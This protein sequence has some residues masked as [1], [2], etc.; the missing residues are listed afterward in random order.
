MRKTLLLFMAA[1]LLSACKQEVPDNTYTFSVER[2]WDQNYSAFPSIEQ[3]NGHYFISFREGEDHIF[4]RNGIAAGK[5]RILRSKDGKEWESVALLSKEG[6]DLRDPKLSITPDG[7]L[8]IIMG[9]S[10]YVNKQ[11]EACIPQVSFSDDGKTFSDP[12]PVNYPDGT[13]FEW[14][15]RMTWH[16]GVGYTVTYSKSTNKRLILIKT[17]DGINYETVSKL[18][19]DGFPNETTVRFLPDGRM[20]MLIRRDAAD[21]DG[22]WG[23]AEAPYT[24]WNFKSIKFR[25]G[26][27]DFIV[28][29]E[30]EILAG[31][32]SY[33]HGELR[34]FVWKGDFEGNFKSAFVLPSYDDNSYPGFIR[35]GEEVWMVYYSC[36]ELTREN[37][38]TRAGIYLAKLPIKYFDNI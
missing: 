4:D 23:V 6:Y 5:T 24:D 15:W 9:G 14:F 30:D 35:V 34:T 21:M 17:T 31:G 1:V 3:F 33:T 19:I 12:Q 20:A 26:G 8:M 7:R 38:D 36:H 29:G 13:D 22:Y 10:I 2:I 37:G 18:D 28:T 27:P 16:D 32:R 25:I 11:L